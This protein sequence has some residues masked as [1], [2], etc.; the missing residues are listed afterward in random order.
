MRLAPRSIR[1]IA[2]L[3]LA[4]AGALAA[5]A[6]SSSSSEE[7]LAADAGSDAGVPDVG[8]PDTSTSTVLDASG[9]AETSTS[10]AAPVFD[11][12]PPTEIDGGPGYGGSVP[13]FNGGILEVEPNDTPAEATP[14]SGI[15]CG[16]VL[17]LGDGGSDAGVVDAGVADAGLDGGDAGPIVVVPGFEQDFVKFTLKATTQTYYVN[18]SGDVTLTLTAAGT[19]ATITPAGQVG[20]LPFT[21]DEPIVV[22]ISPN[23]PQ[24]T[25]WSVIVNEN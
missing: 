2:L 11:A 18:F 10:D 22:Q 12:G 19:T 14:F 1:L 24:K 5:A 7:I 3:G 16:A 20:Q 21:K 17:P 13:C 9:A 15:I 6:C 8:S 25:F 4:G 23:Q